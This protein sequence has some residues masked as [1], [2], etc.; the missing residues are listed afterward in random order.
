MRRR[1]NSYWWGTALNIVGIWC[2][3]PKWTLLQLVYF[4]HAEKVS[5]TICIGNKKRLPV[6]LVNTEGQ[7]IANG[8]GMLEKL[9]FLVKACIDDRCTGSNKKYWMAHDGTYVDISG[10]MLHLG[11]EEIGGENPKIAKR[12]TRRTTWEPSYLNLVC[13]YGLLSI[14][15]NRRYRRIDEFTSHPQRHKE[16]RN[17]IV[18][19][20]LAARQS[21]F[22]R[23]HTSSHSTSQKLLKFSWSQSFVFA[24]PTAYN[25]SLCW[26]SNNLGVPAANLWASLCLLATLFYF[27][28]PASLHILS[29]MP[30][31]WYSAVTPKLS[32]DPFGHSRRPLFSK[33]E[34]EKH[35]LRLVLASASFAIQIRFELMNLSAWPIKNSLPSGR[36]RPDL[37]ISTIWTYKHNPV[38][39]HNPC[40]QPRNP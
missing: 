8:N 40:K 14:S 26:Y 27:A 35:T 10:S 6:S 18:Y 3:Q 1:W 28:T 37:D 24:R 23:H 31:P 17:G 29:R 33:I 21:M 12:L 32:L 5:R 13:H 25:F 7:V 9:G 20:F 2:F 38:D 34:A 36:Y 11:V 4:T 19:Q 16:R 39:I 30:Y 22:K 15:W